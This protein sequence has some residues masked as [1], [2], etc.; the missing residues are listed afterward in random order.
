MRHL[1]DSMLIGLMLLLTACGG[2]G[3]GGGGTTG[4]SEAP[5]KRSAIVTDVGA[6]RFLEQA[7][8]GPS[9]KSLNRVKALGFNAY[10]DEQFALRSSYFDKPASDANI[11]PLQ[12]RFF[13]NAINQEDQLR[14]RMAYALSKIFVVTSDAVG[15]DGIFT[16]YSFLLE[17]AFSNY[18]DLLKGISLHPSMGKFLD[19]ANNSAGTPN[20]N[21]ARELMQL[22]SLGLFMLNEDGS[23][24]LDTNGQP[25]PTYTQ[26]DVENLA[27]ALTGWTY[28]T[29]PGNVNKTFNYT[30]YYGPMQVS[31]SIHDYGPKSIIGVYLPSGQTAQ[32]D[33]E[34]SLDVIFRHQNVAPFVSTRLI[35]HFVT[36]NPSPEYIQRVSKV[37]NN[38]GAGIKG[39]LRAV[40]TAILLDEEARRVDYSELAEPTDGKLKEPVIFIT[41]LLR[42]L[43]AESNGYG[44]ANHA[45]S[46]G[47]VLFDPPSVFGDFPPDYMLSGTDIYGPEFSLHTSPTI[48]GRINFVRALMYNQPYGNTLDLSQWVA[49]SADTSKLID[50]L[51]STLLRGMMSQSMRQ[52]LFD[53]IDSI[54]VKKGE[55]RV[56]AGLYIAATSSQYNVQH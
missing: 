5:I 49:I 38:N 28:T 3:G 33:L 9:P 37:F 48:V 12:D 25:I 18:Y 46:M 36:S 54:D 1:R 10:L 13:N 14:Q 43:D 19:M 4:V 39:D 6:L 45:M 17:N 20:E 53:M 44:L 31:E 21:Y 41:G 7:T 29:K 50:R 30:Y 32:Q 35:R 2:G 15:K 23:P 42:A 11:I 40:L 22:F 8:F 24:L 55:L 27:R 16:Y 26:S 51:N 56:R 47:Q 52:V 34:A